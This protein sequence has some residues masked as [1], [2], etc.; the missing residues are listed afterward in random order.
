VNHSPENRFPTRVNAFGA[1]IRSSLNTACASG[2][3]SP[4]PLFNG[5]GENACKARF[6]KVMV[7]A[8]EAIAIAH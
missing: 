8:K 2:K 6:R 4:F 5:Q 3:N 7:A 1:R